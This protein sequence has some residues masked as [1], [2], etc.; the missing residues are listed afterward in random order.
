MIAIYEVVD[1]LN[2]AC[3][4]YVVHILVAFIFKV[5]RTFLDEIRQTI[6][7]ILSF[8]DINRQEE[9]WN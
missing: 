7:D 4:A 3:L 6:F 1:V 9:K 5:F 2:S 8:K